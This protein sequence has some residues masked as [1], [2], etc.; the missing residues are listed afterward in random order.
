MFGSLVEL[1]YHKRQISM[2]N[3]AINKNMTI[4]LQDN[5]ENI[6]QKRQPDERSGIHIQ[7]HVKIFDPQTNQVFVNGRA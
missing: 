4:K 5:S 1:I 7:G 2:D 6:K 3:N